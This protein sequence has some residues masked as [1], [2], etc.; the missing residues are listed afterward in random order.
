MKLTSKKILI[1][2][3]FIMILLLS[4]CT[5][6]VTNHIPEE[7]KDLTNVAEEEYNKFLEYGKDGLNAIENTVINEDKLIEEI[8]KLEPIDDGTIDGAEGYHNIADQLN[9]LIDILNIEIGLDLDYLQ[10]TQAEYQTLSKII[11]EYTP[12]IGNY[13]KIVI[14]AQEYQNGKTSSKDIFYKAVAEFSLEF[15]IIQGAVF[16][17]PAYRVTGVIY[18]NIGLNRLAFKYPSVVSHLLSKIHWLLRNL[19]VNESSEIAGLL[20]GEM[21]YLNIPR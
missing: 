8:S 19:M 21:K 13:N 15:I 14:S 17:K 1:G 9:L 4:G 16:Y 5:E 11:T 18:R 7:L 12:L 20:I 2:T 10:G 6:N 3:I